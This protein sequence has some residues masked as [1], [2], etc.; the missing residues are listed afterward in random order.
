[1]SKICIELFIFCFGVYRE[2]PM[3]VS[4]IEGA[5]DLPDYLLGILKDNWTME[6]FD[7]K[8][9]KG[10]YA[11]SKEELMTT[12][13]PLMPCVTNPPSDGPSRLLE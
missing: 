12:L 11:P 6:V 13:Q 8:L 3:D 9:L 2:M 7:L 4:A 1:M 10:P 5:L